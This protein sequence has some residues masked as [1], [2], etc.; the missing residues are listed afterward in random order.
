[1]SAGRQT[2]N[3]QAC[4]RIAETWNGFAP[5]LLSTIGAPLNAAN[6]LAVGHQPWAAATPDQFFIK[7]AEDICGFFQEHPPQ[8]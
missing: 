6:F 5:I 2:D 4:E 3:K 8:L 7:D 1:M